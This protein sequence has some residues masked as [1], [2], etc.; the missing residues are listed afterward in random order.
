MDLFT[1]EHEM[2]INND[3]GENE[4]EREKHCMQ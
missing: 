1:L 4:C 3:D 2:K